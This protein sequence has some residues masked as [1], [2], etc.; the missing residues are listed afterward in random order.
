[1]GDNAIGVMLGNG[2]YN[3]VGGGRYSKWTGSAGVRTLALKMTIQYP[4]GQF[5][6]VT[7]DESWQGAVGPITFNGTVPPQSPRWRGNC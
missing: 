6:V 1:M 3:N 5:Q 4:D 7:S 2:M